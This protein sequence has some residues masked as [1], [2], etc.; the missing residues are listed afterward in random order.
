MYV[1]ILV[2]QYLIC[3][4]DTLLHYIHLWY[5]ITQP[6]R[7]FNGVFYIHAINSVKVAEDDIAFK[8]AI[9]KKIIAFERQY[10]LL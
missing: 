5:V 6:N 2:E 8:L 3:V 1:K 4:M 7:N 9:L 10:M